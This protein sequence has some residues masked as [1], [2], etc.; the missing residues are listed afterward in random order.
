MVLEA[1]RAVRRWYH[2]TSDESIVSSPWV[3]YGTGYA[4]RCFW[5]LTLAFCWCFVRSI[6]TKDQ[7]VSRST[8]QDTLLRSLAMWYCWAGTVWSLATPHWREVPGTFLFSLGLSLSFELVHI[9][10]FVLTSGESQNVAVLAIVAHSNAHP[11][12]LMCIPVLRLLGDRF[13]NELETSE[14]FPRTTIIFGSSIQLLLLFSFTRSFTLRVREVSKGLHCSEEGKEILRGRGCRRCSW[15]AGLASWCQSWIVSICRIL[16]MDPRFARLYA[17]EPMMNWRFAL[18][19]PAAFL[20]ALSCR[21]CA[22][23]AWQ[24]LALASF[25]CL[26]QLWIYGETDLLNR[27][28]SRWKDEMYFL[29]LNVELFQIRWFQCLLSTQAMIQAGAHFMAP[30]ASILLF[31]LPEKTELVEQC[32]IEWLMCLTLLLSL[33]MNHS[34]DFYQRQ[35]ALKCLGRLEEMEMVDETV[36]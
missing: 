22:R 13:W 11:L 18:A 35:E 24:D 21:K 36:A 25:C 33:F 31:F 8:L 23:Q 3:G 34:V 4:F 27:E 2:E 16:R 19:C 10:H 12:S 15:L 32:R 1:L 29:D 9:H 17:E 5:T 30:L 6:D 20:L 7:W 14:Y 28:A 26:P